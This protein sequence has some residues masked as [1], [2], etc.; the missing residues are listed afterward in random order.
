M[1]RSSVIAF[2][3]SV[4]VCFACFAPIAKSQNEIIRA[5]Q[6]ELSRSMTELKLDKLKK[7]YYIEYTIKVTNNT[8]M[9]A[10]L[11][12]IRESKTVRRAVLTVG[13]RVGDYKFDNTNFFDFSISFFG[14]GDEEESFR[15]RTISIEPDYRALRREIWLATD[16]AYKRN[17][18]ALTKKETVLKNRIR[19]DSIPDFIQLPASEYLE[20]PE[21]PSINI[22]AMKDLCKSLSSKFRAYPEISTSSCAFEYLPKTVYYVNSEGRKYIKNETSAGL[23]ISAVTQAVDGMPVG[24]FYSAYGLSPKDFPA[25]DSL[26]R[27]VDQL[28]AKVLAVKSAPTLEES[29]SGPVLFEDQA[30]AEVFAQSFA[31]CLVV[32]REQLTEA[33]RQGT[34]SHTEFQNKI[35]GR[36]LPEFLSVSAL[37][38]MKSY[39]GTNLV[40]SFVIDDEGVKTE[41]VSLV[42]DGFL[43]GLL[44]GRVPTKRIKASNGHTRG[45]SAMLSSIEMNCNDEKA[46]SREDLR[47]RLIQL[48]KDRELPFAVVVKRVMN[49]NLLVTTFQRITDGDFIAPKYGKPVI[50]IVEAVKLFPDG[51]EEIIRGVEGAGFTAQSFKDI[52]GVGNKKYAMN[53]LAQS[54]TSPYMSGGES[55]VHCDVIVPNLLFEDGEIKPIQDDFTK[56]PIMSNPVSITK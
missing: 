38:T 32:Q 40:G 7:P 14:S 53:Y 39:E 51:H 27:A 56:P 36:V 9:E 23:E 30:A 54:V 34:D 35:G 42:K 8:E 5:M 6:D 52:I 15:N 43:K 18:E 21:L 3:M 10:T 50:Q 1:K 24:N 17:A 44:S 2:I 26:D 16:A 41:D 37:P 31:P 45:G 13:V 49:I 19:M 22:D 12:S 55:F 48:C 47:E 29:Y 20:T 4:T 33:G 11:G 46:V 25:K 28:I